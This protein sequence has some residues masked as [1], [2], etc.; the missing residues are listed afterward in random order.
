MLKNTIQRNV[1][2]ENE[3]NGNLT[4]YQQASQKMF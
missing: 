1:E 2:I 4:K 3:W